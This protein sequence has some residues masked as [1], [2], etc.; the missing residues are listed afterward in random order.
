M[1]TIV[2]GGQVERIVQIAEAGTVVINQGIP[3]SIGL[4]AVIIGIISLTIL[5]IS[6]IPKP[7]PP[8][9]QGGFNVAVAEFAMI[10]S[11]GNITSSDNVSRQFSDGLFNTIENETKQLPSAF[12]IELRGPKARGTTSA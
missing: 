10:D 7:I 3:L 4:T 2:Y 12:Q 11:N 1:R 6:K 9:S 5:V 8:M